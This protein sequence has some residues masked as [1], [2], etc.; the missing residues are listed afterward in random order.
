MDYSPT[1]LF[2]GKRHKGR[3]YSESATFACDRTIGD[4]CSLMSPEEAVEEYL[5]RVPLVFQLIVWYGMVKVSITAMQSN[6]VT[7]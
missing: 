6:K 5:R 4:K 3:I 1:G 2:Q 7:L